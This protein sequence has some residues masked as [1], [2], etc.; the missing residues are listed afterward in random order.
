MRD[1]QLQVVGC[2][3]SHRALLDGV[4]RSR[5]TVAVVDAELLAPD[6]GAALAALR[7][8][9]PRDA[10]GRARRRGRRRDR[11]RRSRQAGVRGVILRSSPAGAAAEAVVRVSRGLTSFPAATRGD[12]RRSHD[13]PVRRSALLGSAASL[14]PAP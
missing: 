6:A 7:R 4:R 14:N 13:A 2:H 9:V 11:A 5:P 10:A 12:G 8:G 1:H 3:D